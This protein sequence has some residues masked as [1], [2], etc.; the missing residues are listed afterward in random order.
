[1]TPLPWIL[2]TPVPRADGKV[3]KLPVDH[4]SL[5]VANAHDPAIWTD[6]DTATAAAAVAGEG[7]YSGVVITSGHWFLDI[8]HC[9]LPD[10]GWSPIA[11]DLCRRFNGA[12]MEVS[13][14]G[15]GIHII[16]RGTPPPHT[17]RNGAL[18]LEL[19]SGD[20]FCAATGT[21]ARGDMERDFTDEI[22][23]VAAQYFPRAIEPAATPIPDEGPCPEWSGPTDD[24]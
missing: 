21:D 12:Y 22:T 23:L 18:G 17:T 7:Y 10:G 3:D 4:R 1:M 16:G 6:R 13:Q 9:K 8:D 20:R 5:R 14:S 11:I 2:W 15:E 24:D 19:Y